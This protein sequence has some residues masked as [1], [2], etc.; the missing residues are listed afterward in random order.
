MYRHI[1]KAMLEN[2]DAREDQ[3][4]LFAEMFPGGV[5]VPTSDDEVDALLARLDDVDLDYDW[6]ASKLL[7]KPAK[8]AYDEAVEPAKK[9]Y[10]EAVAPAWKVYAETI[11]SA[12]KVY[13]ETATP[14][15]KVYA[16]AVASTQKV[17]IEACARAFIQA[18]R[19]DCAKENA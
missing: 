14:A 19:D 5:D 11:A 13:A 6:A 4:D 9:V 17:Y 16:E 2:L 10:D 8:K 12:W 1:T 7:S 15:E 3:V 18:W